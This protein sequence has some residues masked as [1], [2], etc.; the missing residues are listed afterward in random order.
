[1]IT[2]TIYYHTPE[3]TTLELTPAGAI[4]RFWAW[5][6][7]MI[8][9]VVILLV[10]G[11]ILRLLE[12]SGQ[13]LYLIIFFVVDWLYAVLFEVYRDGQTIG[14]KA[15]GIKVCTD[16]GMAVGWQ[17]SM[18]RNILRVADFLPMFFLSGILAMLFHDKS[19]RLG[20]M[21]AGTMVVYVHGDDNGYNIPAAAPMTPAIP[22]LFDEQR[23]ILAFAERTDELPEQ[24]HIEL[25]TILAPMTRE[26]APQRVAIEL[27]GYANSII[28][29][30]EEV[31]DKP[32]GRHA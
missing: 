15:F 17:A 12:Q 24:R 31:V 1:M 9:R 21:V 29:H 6:M 7:D 10:L 14:K 28:G 18:T 30:N 5:L 3:G 20:D 8:I 13:G 27:I 16:D 4:P 11:F 22:L 26:R 23:A 19:K 32:R 2:N 25:A